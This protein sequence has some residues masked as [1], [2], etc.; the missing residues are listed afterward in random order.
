[1]MPEYR[2]SKDEELAALSLENN[3]LAFEE[4]VNRY[5]Q[6]I[7]RYCLRILNY[8]EQD[9]EDATSETFY[10][11]FKHLS[12][13]NP[14]LKFSSWLYRIAHNTSVNIIR[15]NSKIFTVRIES[16]FSMVDPRKSKESTITVDELEKILNKLSPIDKSLLVLFHLEEKSLKE[17]SD[18]F[19]LSENTIAVKLRRARARA[20]KLIKQT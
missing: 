17:I 4:L 6:P 8:N 9:G 10:K 16:F 5:Q 14:K 2:N 11:A 13:Y 7:Y 1:M 20:R 19:K 18:I 3:H 15:S 12:S